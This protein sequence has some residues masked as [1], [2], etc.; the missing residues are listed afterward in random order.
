LVCVLFFLFLFRALLRN[1]W[2]AAVAWVLF[3]SV[4]FSVGSD[5]VPVALV[6]DLIL[7]VVT[8]FL[9]RR[10][11]LLWLVVSFVFFGLFDEFPLTT[12]IS[13]WYAALSLAGILL[14]AAMAFYGFYTSLGGRPVF[15]SPVLEE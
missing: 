12:Q 5:S 7:N 13:T 2:A 8:V 15:G 4:F 14:M 11:G 3:L 9:L 6:K 10:L 1:E